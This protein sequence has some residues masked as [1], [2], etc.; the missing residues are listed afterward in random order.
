MVIGGLELP[1]VLAGLGDSIVGA[2]GH[3]TVS[4]PSRILAVTSES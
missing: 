4:I 2:L 3:V 1:G